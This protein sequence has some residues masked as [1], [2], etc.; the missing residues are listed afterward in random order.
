MM[1]LV[2]ITVLSICLD[3]VT[4]VK[5]K[6][7]TFEWLDSFYCFHDISKKCICFSPL[8]KNNFFLNKH[9]LPFMP[10]ERNEKNEQ[11]V[12]KN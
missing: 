3:F 8:K 12:G 10:S 11:F 7:I 9:Q 2:L 4:K 1:P 6:L 5:K